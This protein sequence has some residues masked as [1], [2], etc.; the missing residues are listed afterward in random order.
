MNNIKWVKNT[1]TSPLDGELDV[2]AVK[3]KCDYPREGTIVKLTQ[4]KDEC[5]NAEIRF[6]VT[7]LNQGKPDGHCEGLCYLNYHRQGEWKRDANG[8]WQFIEEPRQKS[9]QDGYLHSV[10]N[11]Y[12]MSNDGLKQMAEQMIEIKNTLIFRVLGQR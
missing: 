11:T 10:T 12:N 3:R 6:N 8:D 9:A 7:R 5:P 1:L 4:I 2:I